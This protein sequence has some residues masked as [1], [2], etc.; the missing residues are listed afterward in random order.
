ML[1]L[2]KRFNDWHCKKLQYTLEQWAEIRAKGRGQFVLRQA[3]TFTVFATALLD[4]VHQIFHF[5]S[6]S[7]WGSIAQ[8]AF[9]GVFIGYVTWSE[10]EAKYKRALTS[11]PQTSI[12][13][14]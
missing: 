13:P 4:V 11:S 5:G 10:K 3:F 9:T 14:Q 1:R 6:F 8:Y 7:L 12:Q 2:S